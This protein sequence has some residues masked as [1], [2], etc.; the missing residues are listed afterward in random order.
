[1]VWPVFETRMHSKARTHT[2]THFCT[3]A[4][5]LFHTHTH[6]NTHTQAHASPALPTP[7]PHMRAAGHTG[8]TGA[9]AVC[10]PPAG[11][12]ARRHPGRWRVLAAVREAVSHHGCVLRCSDQEPAFCSLPLNVSTLS[13][14][15]AIQYSTHHCA[16]LCTPSHALAPQATLN[17]APPRRCRLWLR[18]CPA[19]RWSA[20]SC[21]GTPA[22]RTARW[23]SCRQPGA[24]ARSAHAPWGMT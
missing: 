11:A 12:A 2:H 19:R 10:A 17:Q 14:N 16:T 22:M 9:A 4:S 20:Q 3:H 6:A 5:T 15:H 13:L 23:P 18:Q 21:S 8:G 24:G 7:F 1:V